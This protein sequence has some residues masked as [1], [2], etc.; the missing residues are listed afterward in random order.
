MATDLTPSPRR[1]A[2][3]RA[4]ELAAAVAGEVVGQVLGAVGALRRAKPLHPRGTVHAATLERAGL[5]RDG[6]GSSRRG[7]VPLTDEAGR[8]EGHVRISR[9]MGLPEPLPDILGAAVR[10]PGRDGTVDLLF[11]TTGVGILTRY[12]LLPRRDAHTPMTTLMPLRTPSGPLQLRLTPVPSPTPS[13]TRAWEM[14]AS[15]PGSRRWEPFARLVASTDPVGP[16]SDPPLRFDPV[17]NI[18]AGTSQYPWIARV[19]DPAYVL[20]RRRAPLNGR[21]RPGS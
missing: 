17:G 1:T 12:V 8:D 6:A 11:A 4:G 2:A 7:G 14:S 9:A 16:D 5:A 18:P 3:S 10:L 13:A 20:A 21:A 15:S 19:R